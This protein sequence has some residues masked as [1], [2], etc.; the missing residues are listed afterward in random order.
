[1]PE[2]AAPAIQ[3]GTSI[4]A[5]QDQLGSI[6]TATDRMNSQYQLGIQGL[7]DQQKSSQA[8]WNPYQQMGL[9]GIQGIK[10]IGSDISSDPSFKFALQSGSNNM[11]QNAAS[12]GH[13]F[14]PQTMQA[15][16]AYGQNIG[17]EWYQQAFQNQMQQA[18]M[19]MQATGAGTSQG[20]N[21]QN[22]LNDIYLQ[23]G[24][25]GAQSAMAAGAAR[26]GEWGAVGSA[27]GGSG[28][29]KAS[30]G[31]SGGGGGGVGVGQMSSMA[32]MIP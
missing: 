28:G 18:N 27:A 12:R 15:L 23:R 14:S 25:T 30:K 20:L 19:G 29:N 1:M 3:L 16:T 21:I 11:N 13:F 6:G 10:N 4:M 2:A 17:S 31:G 32:T 5:G 7:M 22:M 24:Q 9:E 26:Q 8:A